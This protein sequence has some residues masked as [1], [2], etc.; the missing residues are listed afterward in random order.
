MAFL[1]VIKSDVKKAKS[2]LWLFTSKSGRPNKEQLEAATANLFL[3][4]V[5]Q[6]ENTSDDE[7]IH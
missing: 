1:A 4:L 7:I 2:K 5:F 3:E 6:E